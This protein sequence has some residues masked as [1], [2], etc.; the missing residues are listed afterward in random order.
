M[1]DYNYVYTKLNLTPKKEVNS[2]IKTPY[3]YTELIINYEECKKQ[4]EYLEL[5]AVY[6]PPPPEFVLSNILPN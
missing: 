6:Y 5:N 1:H 3:N 4:F 2:P